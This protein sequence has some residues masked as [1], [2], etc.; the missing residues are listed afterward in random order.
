MTE[1]VASRLYLHWSGCTCIGPVVSA[2]V[3]LYLHWSGCICIG[4]AAPA[5]VRLHPHLFAPADKWNL[6][7]KLIFGVALSTCASEHWQL[8]KKVRRLRRYCQHFKSYKKWVW[9][10]ADDFWKKLFQGFWWKKVKKHGWFYCEFRLFATVPYMSVL[11]VL[12]LGAA[13]IIIT[14]INARLTFTSLQM[15]WTSLL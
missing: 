14:F 1:Q 2:L 4:P 7:Y 9:S 13:I 8:L 5:L 15:N 11:G 3:R 6:Y 10:T 12:L